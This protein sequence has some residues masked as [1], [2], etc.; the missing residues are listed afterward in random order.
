MDF[1]QKFGFRT[2]HFIALSKKS[3]FYLNL[4]YSSLY[5]L[6]WAV[7]LILFNLQFICTY[8]HIHTVNIFAQK[9]FYEE[10]NQLSIL[11]MFKWF[12][13]KNNFYG[14]KS[15]L[16]TVSSQA[17]WR[18][19]VKFRWNAKKALIHAAYLCPKKAWLSSCGVARGLISSS[20]LEPGLRIPKSL[21][22]NCKGTSC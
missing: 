22:K 20:S 6:F 9:H 8:R 7:L 18:K 17:S 5:K 15:E 12:T 10:W 11:I 16:K 14:S 3:Y 19:N 1:V 13:Y 2:N 4:C 21:V